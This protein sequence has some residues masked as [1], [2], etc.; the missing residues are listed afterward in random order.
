MSPDERL[1]RLVNF[2]GYGDYSRSRFLYI[3][4][5]EGKAHTNE[6]DLDEF[7]AGSSED[8]P[9]EIPVPEAKPKN[10][11]ERMQAL[12]SIKLLERFGKQQVVK[13]QVDNYDLSSKYEFCANIYPFGAKSRI[14]QP[15]QYK[16]T[17]FGMSKED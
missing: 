10:N 4:I 7:L 8:I 2:R 6:E 12:L 3:G 11:T 5:E 14:Y 1:S 17:L 13:Q 15:C 9:W 16:D